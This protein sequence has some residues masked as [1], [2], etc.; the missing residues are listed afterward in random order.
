M[1]AQ[2]TIEKKASTSRP[3]T[4]TQRTWNNKALHPHPVVPCPFCGG[5]KLQAVRDKD[6]FGKMVHYIQCV[7]CG[8]RTDDYDHFGLAYQAW[9]RRVEVQN[10]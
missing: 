6:R 4:A 10:A 7:G 8:C 1:M 9:G 5:E 3:A 2:E